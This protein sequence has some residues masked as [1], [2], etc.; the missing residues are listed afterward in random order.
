M[1]VT[2]LVAHLTDDAR[3]QA[4]TLERL[5][6][7]PRVT[8]GPREG[9][10]LALVTETERAEEDAEL[11]GELSRIDGVLQLFVVFHDFSDVGGVEGTVPRRWGRD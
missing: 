10:K 7:D 1:P 6:A 3:E 5:A 9:P 4:R 2:G 11:F 8:L